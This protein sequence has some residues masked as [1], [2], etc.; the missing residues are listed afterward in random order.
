MI[1]VKKLRKGSRVLRF[2]ENGEVGE[3]IITKVEEHPED[4]WFAYADWA[5]D[6]YSTVIGETIQDKYEYGRRRNDRRPRN[7]K[8]N[9][10]ERN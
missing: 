7:Y 8:E 9:Q 4:G 10:D 2:Y 1:E 5:D 3:F 6:D